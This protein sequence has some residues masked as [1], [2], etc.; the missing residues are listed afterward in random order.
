MSEAVEL[1]LNPSSPG[2]YPDKCEV[3]PDESSKCGASTCA[4]G[5]DGRSCARTGI[6]EETEIPCNV[7]AEASC[8]AE[9]V[10]GMPSLDR[11]EI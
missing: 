11:G 8:T 10:Q 7:S 1:G 5:L 4:A 2:G 6:D 9:V 3:T